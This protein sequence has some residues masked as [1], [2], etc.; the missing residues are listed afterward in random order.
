MISVLVSGQ[1]GKKLFDGFHLKFNFEVNQLY[2]KSPFEIVTIVDPEIRMKRPKDTSAYF[3]PFMHNALYF[4]TAFVVNYNNKYF[5]HFSPYFEQRSWSYGVNSLYN[6][7]NYSK[8]S[9]VARDT[10]KTNNHIIPFSME[11]GD[12]DS[13]VYYDDGLLD[14]NISKQG[15]RG[16]I[17]MVNNEFGFKYIADMA[18]TVSLNIDEYVK[19][20]YNR[21]INKNFDIGFNFEWIVLL[22]DPVNYANI[23]SSFGYQ[24]LNGLSLNY[25]LS[26]T[27]KSIK[28]SDKW[29]SDFAYLFSIKYTKKIKNSSL[30]FSLKNRFYGMNYKAL[31]FMD[32]LLWYPY[33]YRYRLKGLYSNRPYLAYY[34]LKNY[35]RPV[36]QY[37]L[38]SEYQDVEYIFGN[39]LYLKWYKQLSKKFGNELE[40]ELINIIKSGNVKTSMFNYIF[41]SNFLYFNLFP[42]CKAGLYITNKQMNLDAQYQT[43]YQMKY[44]FFGVHFTY[45]GLF[46]IGSKSAN[47][48]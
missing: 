40:L 17:R 1:N 19:V 9:F 45:N 30:E 36:S 44:P 46:D 6:Y 34:P 47:D 39:E 33:K 28:W 7:Y 16:K 20:Y 27:T 41:Y 10:L 14:Y 37:A 4:K 3:S 2:Q 38:Y 23:G 18:I 8:F 35:Y 31:N 5:F 42:G 13:I 12:F 26:Y 21:Y 22:D 43:F 48:F 29:P 11:F 15:F 25:S 32:T 24:I